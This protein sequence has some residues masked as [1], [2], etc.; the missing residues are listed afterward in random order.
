MFESLTSTLMSTHL[1]YLMCNACRFVIFETCHPLI[2][3]ELV[4]F[5]ELLR[6]FLTS[7]STSHHG[8]R[9]STLQQAEGWGTRCVGCSRVTWST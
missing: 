3:P 1:T 9:A 5:L 7:H 2:S 4:T 6:V 8:S